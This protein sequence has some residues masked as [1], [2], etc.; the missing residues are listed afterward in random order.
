MDMTGHADQAVEKYCELSGKS[1]SSLKY[2][3]K[4]YIDDHEL[5]PEDF[6][7]VGV[8][9]DVCARIVLKILYQA[10]HQGPDILWSVNA[11]A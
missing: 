3:S 11:L 4:P 2:F 9:T 6:E 10:L 8:R 5:S 7:T 1:I